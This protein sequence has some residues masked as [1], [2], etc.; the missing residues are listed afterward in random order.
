MLT[1]QNKAL[2]L[3]FYKAFD[4]RKME[5]ALALLSPDFIAHLA[6]MPE[7]LNG[8]EFKQFGTSFYSAFSQGQ[9]VFDEIVVTEDRVV[10]C[11][12]FTATHLGKFQEL[13]PTGKQISLSIMHIDKV[14]DEKIVEHWGQ[15]DALGLMQQLGIVFL[16]GPSLFPHIL[17]GAV[18][19]L[20]KKS[21]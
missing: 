21:A 7:P 8:E 12:T 9:H 5:Q 10:T 3:Q 13:P 1:E 6:G 4:D 17:K 18:S 20:F 14:K 15:G 11:G 19:K 2:V 16:P